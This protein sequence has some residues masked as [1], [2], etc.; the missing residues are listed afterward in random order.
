MDLTTPETAATQFCVFMAG[1]NLCEA[2]STRTFG[3]LLA[4][5]GYPLA[6]VAMAS[7]SIFSLALI[8][9]LGASQRSNPTV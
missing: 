4:Y 3:G 5:G 8:P 2:W 6:F 1:I 7:V 9:F